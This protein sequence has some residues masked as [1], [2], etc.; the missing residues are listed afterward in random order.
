MVFN[1][2]VNKNS[3]YEVADSQ[4]LMESERQRIESAKSFNEF[5]VIIESLNQLFLRAER[6]VGFNVFKKT[7]KMTLYGLTLELPMIS[8]TDFYKLLDKFNNKKP[9]AIDITPFTIKSEESEEK[10]QSNIDNA[11]TKLEEDDS[12]FTTD[13]DEEDIDIDIENGIGQDEVQISETR[14]T[15]AETEALIYK[16][17]AEI[18]RLRKQV[19]NQELERQSINSDSV[20][21]N[22]ES[23]RICLE[24][25][26]PNPITSRFCS[27]CGYK[28]EEGV[29]PVPASQ[30]EVQVTDKEALE[31]LPME[32]AKL[33]SLKDGWNIRPKIEHEVALEF[34]MKKDGI[35]KKVATEVET[36]RNQEIE[37]ERQKFEQKEVELTSKYEDELTAEKAKALVKMEN[38]KN[39]EIENRLEVRRQFLKQW[40]QNGLAQLNGETSVKTAT[41]IANVEN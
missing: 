25:G 1:F 27:T 10:E 7:E 11:E 14:T 4:G 8:S 13:S 31:E 39:Q 38:D 32:F 5:V 2:G 16:K 33:F 3:F 37:I 34:E 41:S 28:L 30:E 15:R 22:E 17:D 26:T 9:H 23:E 19:K 20:T 18:E 40:Y 36:K 29:P 35:L 24:C 6:E 12:I 21:E